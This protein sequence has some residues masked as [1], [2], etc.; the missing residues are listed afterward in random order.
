MTERFLEKR[1]QGRNKRPAVK[2]GWKGW[3]EVPDDLPLESYNSTLES[4]ETQQKRDLPQ[5]KSGRPLKK[6]KKLQESTS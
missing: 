2:P 4:Q 6:S 1:N 5:S 3:V